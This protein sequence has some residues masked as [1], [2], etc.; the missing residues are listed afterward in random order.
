MPIV[1]RVEDE[2]LFRICKSRDS[3]LKGRLHLRMLG[4]DGLSY[5]SSSE[6]LTTGTLRSR[7]R[8]GSQEAAGTGRQINKLQRF[9]GERTPAPAPGGSSRRIPQQ[10]QQIQEPR[11]PPTP[12]DEAIVSPSTPPP[13]R[14][15]KL[16]NFFGER[17][18]DELIVDQLEQFFPNI[19]RGPPA[20]TYGTSAPPQSIQGPAPQSVPMVVP[21]RREASRDIRSKVHAAMVNKRMSKVAHGRSSYY[22]RRGSD[23]ALRRGSQLAGSRTPNLGGSIS[24]SKDVIKEEEPAQDHSQDISQTRQIPLA[25]RRK[26]VRASILPP[27]SIDTGSDEMVSSWGREAL[28]SLASV[29][30]PLSPETVAE[31]LPA[32]QLP[33]RDMVSSSQAIDKPL[34]GLPQESQPATPPTPSTPPSPAPIRCE[35]GKLI[36]QG[37]FGKVF[38]GLNLDSGEL[39]AV[40]QVERSI[41]SG[42]TKKSNDV[43]KQKREDALRREIDFLKEM[44]HI[45]IVRYL[46]SEIT[47][48]S[49]NVFLEYV[50]G[51]SIASCLGRYGAF[52]ED[53][54]RCMTAQILCGLEYLHEMSIIHRDIKG[55]NSGFRVCM[56][57]LTRSIANRYCV[58]S[59]P[60]G[61]RWGCQNIR[62]WYI[63]KE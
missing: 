7:S 63:Q 55:A 21:P 49:F 26:S 39:M 32:P 60:S 20:Y 62:L 40:K 29:P 2:E 23:G 53:L 1:Y 27:Q 38:I 56:R 42:D 36:G 5:K 9:F 34:P 12:A 19:A 50:S 37:A 10:F 30:S 24:L 25:D 14:S 57:F 11:S 43:A 6:S 18:P 33:F 51:G 47:D 35:L 44:E 17:P 16:A 15:R 22:S 61:C 8:A 3:E 13:Q 31:N 46:G 28:A 59:S 4:A 45:N 48:T 54:V 58:I 41:L 52:E